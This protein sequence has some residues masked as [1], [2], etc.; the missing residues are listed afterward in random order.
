MA[1]GAVGVKGL[2]KG[3][4]VV[5]MREGK[6]RMVR[7]FDCRCPPIC[8]K[9]LACDRCVAEVKKKKRFGKTGDHLAIGSHL[10]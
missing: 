1:A 4:S 3:S 5:V 8:P 6:V 2:L 9:Q 7:V 10:L